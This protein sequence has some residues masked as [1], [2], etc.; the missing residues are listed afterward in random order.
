MLQ[1]HHPEQ[2][3]SFFQVSALVV[4]DS[5]A[6][7]L[8]VT[9]VKRHGYSR[10]LRSF[11]TSRYK[12]KYPSLKFVKIV[13]KLLEKELFSVLCTFFVAAHRFH[14]SHLSSGLFSFLKK[15]KDIH[16]CQKALFCEGEIILAHGRMHMAFQVSLSA[17]LELR[18]TYMSSGVAPCLLP[19]Y[20]EVHGRGAARHLQVNAISMS[21]QDRR[22]GSSVYL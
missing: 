21:R 22:T 18:H 14:P 6:L 16:F 12:D 20:S 15:T 8:N 5:T 3:P 1:P 10:N 13:C 11:R 9:V 17:S 7:C 19:A 2:T 4:P